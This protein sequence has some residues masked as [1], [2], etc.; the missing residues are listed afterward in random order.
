V[1]FLVRNSTD[2]FLELGIGPHE[3]PVGK[4]AIQQFSPELFHYISHLHIA[5]AGCGGASSRCCQHL[6]PVP[7]VGS[8]VG[9]RTATVWPR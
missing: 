6:H 9:F 8:L 2:S 5:V 4:D 3:V 7:E 1:L